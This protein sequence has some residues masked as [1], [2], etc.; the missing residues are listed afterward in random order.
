MARASRRQYEGWT[1]ENLERAAQSLRVQLTVDISS[2]ARAALERRLGEFEAEI[3]RR[4]GN[5][6]QR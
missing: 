3:G 2:E 4:K 5:G 1:V 6:G